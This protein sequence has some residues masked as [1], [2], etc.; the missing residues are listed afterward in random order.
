MNGIIGGLIFVIAGLFISY[1]VIND[2]VR[3]KGS[4]RG[5]QENAVRIFIVMALWVM[6][7]VFYKYRNPVSHGFGM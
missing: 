3:K 7:Y 1:F 6:A 2:L 5:W 4:A